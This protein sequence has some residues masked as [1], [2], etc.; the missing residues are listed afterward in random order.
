[1]KGFIRILESIIASVIILS[2]ITFFFSVQKPISDQRTQ[3]NYVL[4][5]LYKNGSLS[6]SITSN[7]IAALNTTLKDTLPPTVDFSV[8]IS[9]IPNPVIKIAC[10][11]SDADESTL[12][13]RLSP[14]VFTYRSR[15]LEIRID[16]GNFP[17][18]GDLSTLINANPNILF[19]FGPRTF[20]PAEQVILKNFLQNGTLFMI[21]DLQEADV[22]SANPDVV[23]DDLFG[24]A[25]REGG[26]AANGE[27][28]DTENHAFVSYKISRYYAA[29]GGSITDTFR[30]TKQNGPVRLN[31]VDIDDRTIITDKNGLGIKDFSYV[32][33]NTIESR[34]R[35]VWFA[36]HETTNAAEVER[37]DRLLKAAV[38][39]ASGER[40]SMDAQSNIIPAVQSFRQYNYIGV[41][42]GFEPFMAALKIWGV[43]Y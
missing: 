37:L 5:T 38:L 18:D 6:D 2:S 39:W 35:T 14:L 4:A 30:F 7:N 28:L 1:M 27:F 29:L 43:F 41:L 40:Y 34:G 36:G 16:N 25:W 31:H 11:C 3:F 42:D 19:F 22:D 10:A 9:G 33:I 26:L 17:V 15:T 13:S 21:A 12:S 20:T 24:L 23:M 32:K 8:E